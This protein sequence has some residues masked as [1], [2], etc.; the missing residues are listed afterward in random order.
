MRTTE[1]KK[2][3]R[4]YNKLSDFDFQMLVYKLSVNELRQVIWYLDSSKIA[5]AKSEINI[6]N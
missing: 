3:A 4:K 6:K 5:I 2:Q 1:M